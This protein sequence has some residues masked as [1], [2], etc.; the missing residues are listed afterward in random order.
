MS[1]ILVIGNGF[2][3]ALGYDSAYTHFINTRS[4]IE[5]CFW[6]FKNPDVFKSLGTTLYQH[7]YE[8]F[9][10]H[11]DDNNSIKWI[12]LETE[13][14]NYAASKKGIVI[15]EELV[16]HDRNSFETLVRMLFYYLRRHEELK[17]KHNPPKKEEK[18]LIS[19]L[20]A[21]NSDKEF[22]NAYT[23]NY[24]DLRK[25]L[26]KYGGFKEINLPKITYIHGSL[27]NSIND[28][29]SIVLG[30]NTDYSLPQEYSFLQKINNPFA[31]A[32]DLAPDLATSDEIIFYGLSMGKIDFEYFKSFFKGI[33][34]S[35]LSAQKKHISIFT[36]GE[37]MVLSISQ[38]I[39]EMG[40]S[41]RELKEHS[42]FTII[43][44]HEAE[45]KDN[46]HYTNFQKLLHRLVNN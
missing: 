39:V 6:P 43:D 18:C 16:S 32:G 26:I 1:T 11:L 21:L 12:D 22:K 25:R 5:H 14:Y 35:P 34:D 46:G 31:D 2:D 20:T 9:I 13:P 17:Y 36:K 42:H 40:F 41:I 23:F 10:S 3:L 7:F 4:G 44:A 37:K 30:I 29:P 28:E 27:E 38:N 33:V 45:F 15:P 24:T 8:Y 19:L